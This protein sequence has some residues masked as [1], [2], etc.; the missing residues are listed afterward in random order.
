MASLTLDQSC[1]HP[2]RAIQQHQAGAGLVKAT[3]MLPP[4]M[5]VKPGLKCTSQNK[6][7]LEV[8]GVTLSDTSLVGLKP[9]AHQA[10]ELAGSPPP[11]F[12][13]QRHNRLGSL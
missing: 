13:S 12:T 11:V 6:S 9:H 8:A 4:I 5:S 7:Q 1:Q 2:R 10:D 3:L